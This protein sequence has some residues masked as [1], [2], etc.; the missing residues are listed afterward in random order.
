MIV[1]FEFLSP[2]SIENVITCIN[3]R[4]DRVVCFGRKS[5]IETVGKSASA[6]LKKYCGVFSVEFIELPYNNLEGTVSTMEKVILSETQK[7][8][9][10]FFDI[11]GGEG[12]ALMSFGILSE[13]YDLP[14][15]SFDIPKNQLKE[16]GK[17][18][19]KLLSA[20]APARR[21]DLTLEKYIELYG[22][23]INKEV[24]KYFASDDNEEALRT[25]KKV[26]SV[27]LMYKEEWNGFLE[28]F[29]NN[30][31][32]DEKLVSSSSV[33][34][35]CR[36]IKKEGSPLGSLDLLADILEELERNELLAYLIMN[37][38]IIRFRLKDKTVLESLRSGGTILEAIVYDRQRRVSD[39]C[40]RGVHIDWDGVIHARRG[41]DVLNEIDVL[42]ISGNVPTFI[43]CKSGKTNSGQILTALYE[44]ETVANRFGG[45]YA[46]KELVKINKCPSVNAER[47]KEMGIKLT[48]L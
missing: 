41:I 48:T 16:Y 13:K 10:L 31:I 35:I 40:M 21:V 25:V 9:K 29:R 34:E 42:S 33:N 27:S 36:L 47:A 46:K 24:H 8:N 20:N 37:D 30:L 6:F 1:S 2:E 23:I 43:S 14:M 26:F 28:F 32:P 12:L 39:H 17:N 11:T 7:G 22:G 4:V 3:Y 45:K 15:H 38:D 18:K 44:L 19:D 5:S